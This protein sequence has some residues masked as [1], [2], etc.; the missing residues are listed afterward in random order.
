[1]LKRYL[2]CEVVYG[3]FLIFRPLSNFYIERVNAENEIYTYKQFN[4]N[5]LIILEV[6]I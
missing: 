2:I 5:H 4:G 6:Y 1:M 3:D